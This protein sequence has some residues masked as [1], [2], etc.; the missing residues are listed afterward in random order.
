ME[1]LDQNLKKELLTWHE[2]LFARSVRRKEK[3]QRLKES[4]GSICNQRCLLISGGDAMIARNLRQ[5]GT[6]WE[7]LGINEKAV[8]GLRQILDDEVKQ[9]AELPLPYEDNSFDTL[10]IADA[11]ECVPQD[12]DFIKDCHRVLKSDGRL[13]ITVGCMRSFGVIRGLNQLVGQRDEQAGRL[14]PGYASRQLFDILKDGFDVPGI[15]RYSGFFSAFAGVFASLAARLVV[16]P[17]YEIPP[18]QVDQYLFYKY[19]HLNVL[20]GVGYAFM[21]LAAGLDKISGFLPRYNLIAKTKPR[22]WRSRKVPV[23]ADGRS[24]AEAALNTKIGTAVEF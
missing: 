22:T 16:A 9:F 3:L 21:L 5:N 19:R 14:R 10:I 23:L 11:L 6:V 8:T 24:I 18:E 7:V 15:T 12:Y 4:L 20:V 17:C 1:K 13:I 2:K